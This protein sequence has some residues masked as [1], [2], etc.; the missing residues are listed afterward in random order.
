MSKILR[1]AVPVNNGELT[2]HFGHALQF[3]IIDFDQEK[4]E[5]LKNEIQTPPPHEPGVLP[6]WL[7]ELNVQIVIT[8]G[9]GR[10][11]QNL[12]LQHGI[13]V[14]T[15]AQGKKPEEIVLAYSKGEL[16]VGGNLC[17]H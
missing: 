8:G 3:A 14:V 12:F 1:C 4:N 5:I 13:Q 17:D 7:N 16:V 11:A 6:Q 2:T 9:M 10:R 15:G